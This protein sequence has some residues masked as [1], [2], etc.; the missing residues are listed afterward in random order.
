MTYIK[1]T[2]SSPHNI[3]VR[4]SD[5]V[6]VDPEDLDADGAVPEK[7][8]DEAWQEAVND[9]MSDTYVEVVENEGD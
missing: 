5:Y 7:I 6:E 4:G 3:S 8:L 1:I 2:F 9:F